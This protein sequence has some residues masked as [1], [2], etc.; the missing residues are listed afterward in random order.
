MIRVCDLPVELL[1][2][3]VR[4]VHPKFGVVQIL[5]QV[6]LMGTSERNY[7]IW[8]DGNFTVLAQDESPFSVVLDSIREV[9]YRQNG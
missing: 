3:G 4:F 7:L 6:P 2:S 8:D 1:V 9:L 5:G